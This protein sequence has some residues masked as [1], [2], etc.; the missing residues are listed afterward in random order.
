MLEVLLSNSNGIT[1]CGELTHIFRDGFISNQRCSCGELTCDCKEWSLRLEKLEWDRVDITRL[2]K[3][4]SLFSS[5]VLFPLI[6]LGLLG[7]VRRAE[8]ANANKALFTSITGTTQSNVIVDSSK[9]AGRALELAAQYPDKVYIIAMTRSPE[10]VLH[11]F[12]KIVPEQE[13]KSTLAT[14]LYYC[15]ALF[16]MRLVCLRRGVKFRKIS[17]ES[18]CASPLKV[19][20]E[21]EDFCG[22]NLE[23]TKSKIE[24]D[25]ALEIGHIVTGNRIRHQNT[26]KFRCK[27]EEHE[28][29]VTERLVTTLMSCWR[30]LL[31]F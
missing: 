19:L 1:S 20:S 7:S 28:V 13:P 27:L 15:Y 22:V 11:S 14:M 25:T 2:A 9:Y 8:Y 12:T 18:L 26:I 6:F 30:R 21:I 24:S 3:L 10:N 23:H 31:G 17:Y 4:F 5:H 16:C 29:S